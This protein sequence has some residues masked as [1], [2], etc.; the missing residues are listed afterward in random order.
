MV[1]RSAVSIARA[2]V[3]VSIA[4]SL[5]ACSGGALSGGAPSLAVGQQGGA[6]PIP[7]AQSVQNAPAP[8]SVASGS[9][10]AAASTV[11][12]SATRTEAAA[13][14]STLSPISAT[15]TFANGT[16]TATNTSGHDQS[17]ANVQFTF[18]D[19]DQIA[20]VWGSP[21]MNWQIANSGSTYT[22]TGGT[23]YSVWKNGATLT[24]S[25]TVP[26]NSKNVPANEQIS[27]IVPPALVPLAVGA[28]ESAGTITIANSSGHPIA[29]RSLELDFTYAGSIASVW[30]TPWIAWTIARSGNA[31][32]LT[33]GTNDGTQLAAGSSMTV[34]FTPAAGASAASIVL[35]GAY[36]DSASPAP[37]VAPTTGPTAH[38]TGAPSATPSPAPTVAPTPTP[39][40]TAVPTAP[41]PGSREFVGFWESWSDTNANDAF[42]T[43]DQIPATVTTADVAFSV[44]SSNAIG[45]PQNTYSLAAGIAAYHAKGGK[46]LLSFGG[47]TSQFSITNVTQFEANLTAYVEAHPGWYDGF[48]FDDE[49]MPWNGQ[50]QLINV[51]N[52][53]RAAFP[54]AII[55]MDAF[56]SGGDPQVYLSTHQGEDIAVMQQAG[57]ALNYVN[58]MNYDYYGWHPSDHP[59][60][61]IGGADDCYTDVMGD[62]AKVFPANKLVMGLMIA[63]DD[64]GVVLSP[65]AAT[66]Y[67][68]WVKANGYHGIMIW[69]L[70]R[71]NKTVTG[72]PNGTYVNDI[73]SNV[74]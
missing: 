64:S 67:A 56:A 8:A 14:S 59:S 66:N 32:T 34:Q 31:Y 41:P 30:G 13:A 11:A 48:D 65:T 70:D 52:A 50:A 49:V 62:F 63:A 54:N 5:A 68:K 21:W 6:P 19:P 12:Q 45:D 7:Q 17:L 35:K 18:T 73:G 25:F 4:V 36:A 2:F 33:G 37:T 15:F 38:P 61:T 71:D 3:S 58:V 47:A 74:H 44:A 9:A 10:A 27:A 60:C 16:I 22:L 72:N 42:Y 55:S 26:W 46:V 57:A 20:S 53:T 1:R 51:I 24:V 28:S 69:D 23:P 39:L 29:L 43:I 40:P